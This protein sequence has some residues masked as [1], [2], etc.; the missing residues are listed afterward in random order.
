MCVIGE[1]D[2]ILPVDVAE[3]VA[4]FAEATTI[5]LDSGHHFML[6]RP[7]GQALVLARIAARAA[8]AEPAMS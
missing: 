8:L 1:R 7:A 4:A 5:S 2:A 6:S 3:G